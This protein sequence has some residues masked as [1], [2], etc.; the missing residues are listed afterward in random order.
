MG[1]ESADVDGC[2][3][4]LVDLGWSCVKLNGCGLVKADKRGSL[5][6]LHK[7]SKGIIG[8]GSGLGVSGINIGLGTS[9]MFSKC[10]LTNEVFA[11]IHSELD[12]S[13]KVDDGTFG[14][15]LCQL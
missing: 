15:K 3:S 10:V 1:F 4:G 6:T 7:D 11:S 9:S 8:N 13:L 12:A 2:G 14:C 5:S